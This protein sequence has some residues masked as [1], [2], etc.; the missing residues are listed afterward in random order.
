MTSLY[1][2]KMTAYREEGELK[3][4]YESFSGLAIAG[5]LLSLLSPLAFFN[6]M[7]A[8]VPFLAVIV[9]IVA[10][11]RIAQAQIKGSRLA[12]IGLAIALFCASGG[13]LHNV[14]GES[15]MREQAKYVAHQ[16]FD[17]ARR[18]DRIMLHQLSL[19]P[20]ARNPNPELLEDIYVRIAKE[21]EDL[22]GYVEIEPLPTLERLKDGV[23]IEF[24]KVL[25]ETLGGR[26]DRLRLLYLF[27][28]QEDGK[29]K[30]GYVALVV[31]RWA[32]H[33]HAESGWYVESYIA[34]YAG[35]GIEPPPEPTF[36]GK[37][38]PDQ[39]SMQG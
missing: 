33:R 31:K 23:D 1:S 35:L 37:L 4:D 19:K 13:I 29:K 25:K 36:K 7:G 2:A 8:V 26:Y 16:W 27:R 3:S 18:G 6:T 28:F 14:M 22:A 30:E 38:E 10:L 39:D 5:L 15:T 20:D 17:A 11:V 34:D 9:N 24:R 21:R 32:E 12:M